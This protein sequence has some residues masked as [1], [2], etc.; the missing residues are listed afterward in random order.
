MQLLNMKDTTEYEIYDIAYDNVG[1]PYFLI[2][3][4]KRWEIV[5]S[6]Y[7]TPNYKKVFNRGKDVYLVDGELIQSEE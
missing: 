2:Y 7:F 5:H 6:M 1:N 4:N 3:K